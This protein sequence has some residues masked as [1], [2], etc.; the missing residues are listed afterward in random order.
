MDSRTFNAWLETANDALDRSGYRER[1]HFASLNKPRNA[2]EWLRIAYKANTHQPWAIEVYVDRW[3]G[4]MPEASDA[5]RIA[6]EIASQ[7]ASRKF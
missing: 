6:R 1:L 2:N 3:H 4:R 5:E 7:A